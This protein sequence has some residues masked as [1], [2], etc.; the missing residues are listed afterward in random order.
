VSQ[1]PLDI[2][3]LFDCDADA[4]RVDGRLNQDTLLGVAADDERVEKNFL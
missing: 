3:R 4:Q 1:D 2:I